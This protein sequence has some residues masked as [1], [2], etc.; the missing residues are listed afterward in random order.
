MKQDEIRNSSAKSCTHRVY[1]TRTAIGLFTIGIGWFFPEFD[2]IIGN[3]EKERMQTAV[4][5]AI[6]ESKKTINN[7]DIILNVDITEKNIIIPL[8]FGYKCII[9]EGDV[10][11]SLKI[12]K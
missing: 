2:L 6:K 5:L 8:I 7:A 3:K 1:L 11:S 4:D 10:G 9:A 12:F